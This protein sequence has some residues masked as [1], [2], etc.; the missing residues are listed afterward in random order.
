MFWLGPK[1][2]DESAYKFILSAWVHIYLCEATY[3]TEVGRGSAAQRWAEV[4]LF[5]FH[6]FTLLLLWFYAIAILFTLQRF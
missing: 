6:S 2:L 5:F 3:C 1:M 4:V